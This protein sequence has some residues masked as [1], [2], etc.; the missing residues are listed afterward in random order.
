VQTRQF[1]AG[2][3]ASVKAI[4]DDAIARYGRLDIMFANAGIIGSTKI[5]TEI[6]PDDFMKTLRTNTLG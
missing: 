6:E 5:F 4:V 2:D 1:D 3:A